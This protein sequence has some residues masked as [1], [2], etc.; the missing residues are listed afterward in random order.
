MTLLRPSRTIQPIRGAYER[1]RRLENLVQIWTRAAARYKKQPDAVSRE[2]AHTL[3]AC[4]QE[5]REAI[6]EK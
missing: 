2:R 5:L 3:E 1:D 4:A 6:W